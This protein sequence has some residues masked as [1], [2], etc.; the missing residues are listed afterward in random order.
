MDIEINAFALLGG[1]WLAFAA[2]LVGGAMW[3]ASDRLLEDL[4]QSP[5]RRKP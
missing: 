3:R 2:G 4:F 1:L 5:W